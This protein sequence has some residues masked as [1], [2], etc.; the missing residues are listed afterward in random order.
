[1]LTLITVSGSF[2]AD[3]DT[4]VFLPVGS[5][6]CATAAAYSSL[7]GDVVASG[8]VSIRLT[9]PI[10]HNLCLS[11][12]PSPAFD[13]DF[14][15]VSNVQLVVETAPSPSPSSLGLGG[16]VFIGAGATVVI[17][18]LAA[19]VLLC[20][21]GDRSARLAATSSRQVVIEMA[22]TDEANTSTLSSTSGSNE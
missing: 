4:L 16:V 9:E 19:A 10:I 22:T 6:D 12:K 21:L 15:I 14:H 3:G 2:A 11:R 13:T 7:K 5:T 20:D 8:A 1:M 18:I 17:A